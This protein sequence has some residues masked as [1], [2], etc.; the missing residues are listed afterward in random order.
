M[1]LKDMKIFPPLGCGAFLALSGMIGLLHAADPV[2]VHEWGTFTSLQDEHGQAIKGINVDDEP[3]PSFIYNQG[4]VPVT[5]QY[6]QLERNFGLPP[7]FVVTS[8]GWQPGDPDVTMRL[9]TPVIY[10]YPPKGQTAG[11]VPLLNVH[12]DFHGGILSQSYPYATL[13]G[14]SSG[15]F[16]YADQRGVLNT[17]NAVTW[18]LSSMVSSLTWK[19]VRLGSTGK[20]VETDDKVWTT[21]REVS[22]PLLEVTAPIYD[23]NGHH[24]EAQAEHFLFYRGVGHLD[25]PLKIDSTA[26]SMVGTAAAARHDSSLVCLS[27]QSS[28][29]KFSNYSDSWLVDIR[30]NGTCAFFYRNL[31]EKKKPSLPGSAFLPGWF[32]LGSHLA[33]SEEK[34]SADNLTQIKA[35]MQAALVKEGLYPDEASAML[36]T[37][38]LSYFK[39]PGL[40]FFYIVPRA[41]TDKLLPLKITGA[42]TEITRVMVGRIELIT[43]EQKAALARLAAGPCPDL[44]SVKQAALAALQKSTLP[45][46]EIAAFYRGEKPLSA[47]GI[48]LPPL[49]QDYLSLGRFR[50]ALIVHE[51]QQHPSTALAQFIRDNRLAPQAN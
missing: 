26:R 31:S 13:E 18:K 41:W 39:S 32:P 51:Q 42:P 24:D 50:D 23:V 47:L 34:Y 15:I 33:F 14:A 45:K 49:V 27:P 35:S 30:S 25:S 11:S 2:I 36:R 7:Y 8:K 20:P 37:W 21:P 3:V 28:S 29:D 16:G 9:E 19:N 6:S 1:Y 48:P 44:A 38:D 5:A 17:I 10:F 40:R 12:V 4:V 43:D 46:D 22:A